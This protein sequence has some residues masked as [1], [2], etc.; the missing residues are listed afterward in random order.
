MSEGY[1]FVPL[2]REVARRERPEAA[3]HQR[4]EGTLSG[5]LRVTFRAEQPVHVGS[6]QKRLREG[7]VVRAGARIQGQPGVPGS[8]LKGVLR[9][10]YEAITRS[11]V[12][13]PP[14]RKPHKV[15]STTHPDIKHAELTAQARGEA[16]FGACDDRLRCPACALFG[17]M[18]LRSRISVH[19]LACAADATFQIAPIDPQFGPNLHHVGKYTIADAR[20]PGQNGL[21][22]VHRL[23]GR[24]FATGTGPAGDRPQRAL[25]DHERRSAGRTREHAQ[26][27]QQWIEVIPAGTAITG[28]LRLHNVL[29]AELGGLLATLGRTPA[30]ALKLGAG[31][32]CGFGRL[33]LAAIHY[34]LR[35][36]AGRSIEADEPRWRHSF[37]DSSDYW[38]PGET[39][40]ARIHQGG[41]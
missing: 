15:R 26:Q 6:G 23:Y 34:A 13:A 35:D 33:R 12:Q 32:G 36:H 9:S 39:E 16:A 24:K 40:L 1:E 4:C 5:T 10:R 20:P 2:P 7:K 25:P 37:V 18:S 22:Q 41:C 3:W 28:E 31:K 8:S 19:D 27:P 29:P 14:A 21:F 11:C 17:R 38:G 30:S